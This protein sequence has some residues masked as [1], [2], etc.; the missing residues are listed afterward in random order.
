MIKNKGTKFANIYSNFSTKRKDAEIMKK[1][2]IML[3]VLLMTLVTTAFGE[4]LKIQYDGNTVDYTN[5]PMTV[6]VNNKNITMPL[7]PIVFNGRALVPVREV[8][9]SIDSKV[10]Y[11]SASKEITLSNK[12]TSIK[13]TINSNV[14][15]VNDKKTEIPDKLTPKLI[16]KV[17]EDA[18]T[19]VPIRFL[20]ETLGM[21]VNYSDSTRNIAIF[22]PDYNISSR[23]VVL[24]AGH[25]GEDSGALGVIDGKTIMEKDITLSVTEKVR[26]ILKGNNVDVEMTRDTDV[27]PSLDERAEFANSR[28][29]YM[30]VSIHINANEKPEPNGIE[31]YYCKSANVDGD[32]FNGKKLATDIQN[33]LI[34]ALNRNNRGVKTANF[35]VIKKTIMPAV[36]IELGF[37]TNEEE[38][39]LLVDDTYQQKAAQAIADAIISNVKSDAVSKA[40]T[41]SDAKATNDVTMLSK[42]E[43]TTQNGDKEN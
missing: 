18:K 16:N 2:V 26:D 39:K 6:T 42:S 35:V 13:I 32:G 9:E 43:Q 3:S 40:D 41:K 33:N 8:F 25:G 15:Y 12:D 17:G 7:S 37:I 14:A 30:F 23:L 21:T 22:T 4:A 29:A 28:N 19:M 24:D 38:V 5:E 11:N 36:L 1:V 20:S 31:T 34:S 10:S 27:K